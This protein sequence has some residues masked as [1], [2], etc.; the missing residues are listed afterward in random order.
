[1]YAIL[2]DS[3]PMMFHGHPWSNCDAFM[4]HDLISVCP[5]PQHKIPAIWASKK[6]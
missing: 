3:D 4:L 5:S 1:M 6:R 2:S